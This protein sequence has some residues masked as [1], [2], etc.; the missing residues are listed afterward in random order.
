MSYDYNM[1]NLKAKVYGC[2]SYLC[3]ILPDT[4]TIGSK[5]VYTIKVLPDGTIE[6]HKARVVALGYTQEH[7][8]DYNETFAPAVR[9]STVRTLLAV[10]SM[11]NWTLSQLD[12]KNAFLHGDLDEVIYMEKPPGYHVGKHGQV[13]RLKRSLYGLH[14]LESSTQL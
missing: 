8:V 11:K 1:L 13:C 5:W 3:G 6:R 14:G 10:A 4:P 9:M 12:V 7:G 2:E